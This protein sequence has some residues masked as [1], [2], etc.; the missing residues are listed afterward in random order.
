TEALGWSFD[1]FTE[2]LRL[3]CPGVVK[4]EG[5]AVVEKRALV[6]DDVATVEI[7]EG[8]IRGLVCSWNVTLGWSGVSSFSVS[9]V[10]MA[11]ASKMGTPCTK[12]L[13]SRSAPANSLRNASRL[14]W[15]PIIRTVGA[16]SAPSTPARL[17]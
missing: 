12:P 13:A 4:R 5:R 10:T 2:R 15:F 6:D 3:L 1:Q 16:S 9:S 17:A 8:V 11:A 7:D 14:S